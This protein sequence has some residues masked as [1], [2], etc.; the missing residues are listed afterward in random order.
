MRRVA[1]ILGGTF[2]PV[3]LGHLAAAERV[4]EAL[5][6]AE[7][8]L[9][10]CAIPP[11]KVG[12]RWSPAEDRLAMLRIA[13]GG[14]PGLSVST[15][16]LD[17]GGVS[18]TI[19]T[20]RVLRGEHG[21]DPVFVVGTDSLADLPTWR[22]PEALRSEFDWVVVD[23]P[24]REI[25]RFLADAIP[26]EGRAAPLAPPLGAGGRLLRLI[27]PVIPISASDVRRRAARGEP[28]DGLVPPEVAG[29]IQRRGLY[30]EE[31]AH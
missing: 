18:Y 31:I 10:P 3:H 15:L 29:Y 5:G 30:R 4:L 16:E 24:S 23:R 19:E 27:A 12:A 2:D 11:H 6:L 7:V 14:R 26:V 13:V 9:M 25:P 8:I 20:L 28:L 1:G 22:E 21:V 17:R